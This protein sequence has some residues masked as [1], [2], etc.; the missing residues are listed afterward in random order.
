MERMTL[1]IRQRVLDQMIEHA[2]AEYPLEC[3]GLLSG[4]KQTVEQIT[5]ASNERRSARE[6]SIPPE[7]LLAFFK[8]L[9]L[10]ARELLGIYHSHPDS[11]AVPSRHDRAGFHYPEATYWIVSLRDREPDI[12]C[13][14]WGK[15]DFERIAFRVID[16]DGVVN[17][18]ASDSV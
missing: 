4:K 18:S 2:R 14:R 12:H 5:R 17:P 15:M 11:S 1:R 7:E 16:D 8:E 3:C 6:F 13:F 9:R 10:S